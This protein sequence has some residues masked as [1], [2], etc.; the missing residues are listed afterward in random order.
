VPD[1]ARIVLIGDKDQLAAVESGAV[2]AELAAP[3]AAPLARHVVG[4]VD[5]FRFGGESSIGRLARAVNAGD[6]AAATALLRDPPDPGL[7]WIADA[8]PAMTPEDG[9]HP[10]DRVDDDSVAAH[11][12]TT[13]FGP[14]PALRAAAEGFGDYFDALRSAIHDRHR[15]RQAFEAFRVLC[16]LRNGPRGVTAFNDDLTRLAREI[17]GGGRLGDEPPGW[18]PGRPVMVLANDYALGRF[19]GDVGIALPDD[20]GRLR[21]WFGEDERPVDVA[22]LPRHQTAFAITVH[23]S[24]GSE[25]DR[26]LLVMPRR[27]SRVVTR[28]LLY[29]AVTRA[30]T[31][32]TIAAPANVLALAVASPTR[33]HS[34]LS[35]RLTEAA[36]ATDRAR[37]DP[38]RGRKRR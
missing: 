31:R 29:T 26:A 8:D 30:R 1:E 24:Q 28:E 36:L 10:R 34:G 13:T 3:A 7:L 38:A 4:L 5:S 23:Q 35:S 16:A 2:F 21:V 32:A 22:R 11:D 20:A 19:N 9:T 14:D 6:D 25:F 27:P 33:R 12:G 15:V 37:A 18:F 17:V